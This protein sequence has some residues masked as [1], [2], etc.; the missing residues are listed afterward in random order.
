MGDEKPGM[1]AEVGVRKMDENGNVVRREGAA[2]N[3]HERLARVILFVLLTL[4]TFGVW[5]VIEVFMGVI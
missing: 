1:G 3:P 2:A 5:K 4:S